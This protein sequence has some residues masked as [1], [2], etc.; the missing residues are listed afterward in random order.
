MHHHLDPWVGQH[1][2]QR[3]RGDALL[4][5]VQELDPLGHAGD[6]RGRELHQAQQRAVATLAHELRVEREPARRPRPLGELLQ[7]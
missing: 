5:R 2:R 6:L 7:R 1:R 3:R 4:E